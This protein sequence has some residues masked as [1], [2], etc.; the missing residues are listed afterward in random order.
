MNHLSMRPN[1]LIIGAA[2]AAT[3]TLSNLLSR[4]PQAAIVQG[5]EPHFF[6]VDQNYQAGWARYQKLF[7]H[8]TDELAV[9]DA[10]TSYSR[11]RYHPETVRRILHHVPDVKIIYMVR[12]PLQRMESAYVER[13]ATHG[14]TQFFGSIN[15][16]VRQQPMIID[17][18]RYWEVFDHYRKHFD[19]S[20]ILV[21]WFEE[22]IARLN[23]EFQKVCRFLEIDD[24][25]DISIGHEQQN[26]R[27]NAVQRMQ[28]LGCGHLQINTEW[29]KATHRWVVDQICEDNVKFLEHFK[30]PRDFWGDLFN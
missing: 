2:K 30:R 14:S 13:L 7:S 29:D 20:R 15:Q 6:S 25:V 24:A 27:E 9:G 21:V 23:T 10:S 3:T 26:R 17:S 1:F 12:H 5:K 11:I 22:F 4:H 19:E 16:A 28:R 18:S 8:C